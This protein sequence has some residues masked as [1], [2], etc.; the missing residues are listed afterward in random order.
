MLGRGGATVANCAPGDSMD[1]LAHLR[2]EKTAG[3]GADERALVTVKTCLIHPVGC[4]PT[5]DKQ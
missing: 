5:W 1:T 3:G 2:L 4:W